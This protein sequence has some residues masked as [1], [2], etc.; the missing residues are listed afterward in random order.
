MP[1][2]RQTYDVYTRLD[3]D[4]DEDI[5]LDVEAVR[6][7]G[8][9]EF[10]KRAWHLVEPGEYLDNW[11]IKLICAHLEAVTRGDISYLIINIPP[12]C[13]KSLLVSV[14][15]PVWEWTFKSETKWMFAS[16]DA[17]LSRRDALKAKTIVDSKWFKAR[18]P[19]VKIA[20]SKRNA[21]SATEYYID[22]GGMRFSTSVA[23]KAVGWHGDRQV[24]DDPIKPKDTKGGS[25]VTGVK[26]EEV[27]QWWSGTMA[28]RRANPKK[29]ARVVV[30]QRLH[31]NDLTGAC[32]KSGQYVH[33]CLPMEYDPQRK[34]KTEWGEDPRT[35]EG[36]LLWPER[37]SAHEVEDLKDPIKGLGAADYAA[38]YQQLP[39]PKEGGIFKGDYFKKRYKELPEGVLYLMSWDMRFKESALSGSYVC[40]G[41]WAYKGASY[42]LVKVYRGR[43][44]FKQS[45]DHLKL[46]MMSYPEARLILVEDKANGPAIVNVLQEEVT[47]LVLVSPEGGKDARANAV[48]PLFEAGNVWL[49]DDSLG[50][51]WVDEY[52]AEM[53]AFPRGRFN[54]QVD[55]TS[56]ALVRLR[57]TSMF[58]FLNAMKAVQS[59]Q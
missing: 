36:E 45:L 48:Q 4:T 47:G 6:R 1:A 27:K 58:T 43:W 7:G 49:P 29:F 51:L 28:S 5:A 20:P 52:I 38:Q 57:A 9:Y 35:A 18:W 2:A 42:Y 24:V 54:D 41:V 17:S 46:A 37:I 12:G 22:G 34:C 13:M 53:C 10:V 44:S 55:M 32:L 30:M 25:E 40:G 50:E 19:N 3:E 23:G 21:N 31:E 59:G 14:F 11:H 26:L 56:Q 16:F 8:L 39:M 15:W 33:L